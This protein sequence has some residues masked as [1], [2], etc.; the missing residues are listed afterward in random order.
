MICHLKA[1]RK[2]VYAAGYILLCELACMSLLLILEV[3][4]N[5]ETTAARQV[6][7]GIPALVFITLWAVITGSL[8][9]DK[10]KIDLR[11]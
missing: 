8:V 2:F 3:K 5:G 6:S 4:A 10:F 1:R 11:D 9:M 7:A